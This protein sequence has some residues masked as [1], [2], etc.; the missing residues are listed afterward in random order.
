MKINT[1]ITKV[2]IKSNKLIHNQIGHKC[3]AFTVNSITRWNMEKAE[4]KA[5]NIRTLCNTSSPSWW[6]H[7]TWNVQK[8]SIL[9]NFCT[10]H[11]FTLWS[12]LLQF[13]VKQEAKVDILQKN[14]NMKSSAGSVTSKQNLGRRKV[15]RCIW[16]QRLQIS[17]DQ[18]MFN[19]IWIGCCYALRDTL[20]MEKVKTEP[21]SRLDGAVW[22][23]WKKWPT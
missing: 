14:Q 17:K 18:C 12:I 16:G 4:I 20:L 8:F 5:S 19:K 2:E 11:S 1:V 21:I 9:Y 6:R 3:K 22:Y 13:K 23:S 10:M 15:H 7:F